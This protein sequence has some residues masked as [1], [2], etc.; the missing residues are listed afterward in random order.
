VRNIKNAKVLDVAGG[1]DGE[2]KNVIVHQAHGKVNQQWDI[3][4]VDEWKGEP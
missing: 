1:V 4:Y 3:V 2:Q